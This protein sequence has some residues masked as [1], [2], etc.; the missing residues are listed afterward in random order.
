MPNLKPFRD[1]SQHDVI[2]M[3]SYPETANAGTLVKID[4]NWKDT[5]GE[6]LLLSNLTAVNNTMSSSFTPVGKLLKTALATDLAIGV[7]LKN[8]RE[9]DEN[10]NP[11]IYEP[12]LLAERDAV[13]PQQAVP[14]LTRGIILINDIEAV[15]GNYPVIGAAAYVG[16]L[17]RIATSGVNRIGTFLSTVSENTSSGYCLVRLNIQ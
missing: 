14:V 10:G 6:G 13:I 16:T 9:Y 5:F 7:L 12:Q 11:L 17:G 1:Y 8:V 2:N 4:S 15:G 3:F